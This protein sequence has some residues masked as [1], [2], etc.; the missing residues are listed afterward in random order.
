MSTNN[1][2][3][4]LESQ[5]KTQNPMN[6]NPAPTVSQPATVSPEAT[7]S[8]NRG[9]AATGPAPN[10]IGSKLTSTVQN[11][12]TPDRSAGSYD[13]IAQATGLDPTVVQKIGTQMQGSSSPMVWPA[14]VD[15]FAQG[16]SPDQMAKWYQTVTGHTADYYA[17]P[18]VANPQQSQLVQKFDQG[19]DP[20]ELS[21]LTNLDPS[22]IMNAR[23]SPWE[24]GGGLSWPTG[25]PPATPPVNETAKSGSR[26]TPVTPPGA[27]TQVN[28]VGSPGATLTGRPSATSMDTRTGPTRSGTSTGL[29]AQGG[30]DRGRGEPTLLPGNSQY[31]PSNDPYGFPEGGSSGG[32]NIDPLLSQALARIESDQPYN[33][34]AQ[35]K[36]SKLTEWLQA[37]KTKAMEEQA[38]ALAAQGITGGQAASMLAKVSRDYGL[39]LSQGLGQLQTE[40]LQGNIGARNKAL[41]SALALKSLQTNA[42]LGNRQ[43]DITKMLGLEGLSR[44]YA[45]MEMNNIVQMRQLGLN[46]QEIKVN[47]AIKIA[48]LMQAGDETQANNLLR[49]YQLMGYDPSDLISSI[50]PGAGAD[51]ISN[52]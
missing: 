16:S 28:S 22:I 42:Q 35:Q 20:T 17:Q 38:N 40:N 15:P 18:G 36:G 4:Y 34:L 51:S 41:D 24:F 19:M 32:F 26:R 43:M 31:T 33:D 46:E 52:P 47:A 13:S 9:I 14:G 2:W 49:L 11:L 23:Q 12:R 27:T 7:L 5:Q 1:L 25:A 45:Q 8:T 30:Y 50:K 39:G 3:T 29:G 6:V 48:Q 44:D 21:K 10:Q 37:A